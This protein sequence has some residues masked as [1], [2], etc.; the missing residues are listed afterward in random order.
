M[1][2]EGARTPYLGA[3]GPAG[4]VTVVRLYLV[5]AVVVVVVVVVLLADNHHNATTGRGAAMP[6]YDAQAVKEAVNL[7]DLAG[8]DTQLRRISG[9]EHA[10][11][12]PKCGGDDRFHVTPEWWFC[13]QCHERRGDAI[14]YVMWRD[15]LRFPDACEVLGG[16]RTALGGPRTG[17][18][19]RTAPPA[20]RIPTTAPPGDLWQG[21]ARSLVAYCE[22]LLW[23]T[24]A[25]LAHL[26]GRGLREDTIRAARLGWSEGYP[27]GRGRGED[28]ARW[29]VDPAKYPYGIRIPRG[30]VIPCEVGGQLRYIKVRRPPEDIAADTA[31]TGKD[32][33]KYLC[34]AGGPTAGVVYGLDDA[35]GATDVVLCEGEINA[36][37]L[38]QALE[39]VA[40]V[41]SV[42]SASSPPPG[43]DA[44]RV[45]AR[46]PRP[47][48][49]YDHDEQGERGAGNLQAL[50]ARVQPLSWPWGDRGD[51]YDI[52]DAGRDGEDLAAWCV[53]QLGPSEPDR[54]RDWL[55]YHLRR[56]DDAALEAGADDTDPA[57]RVWL[58]LWG[59]LE[60]LGRQNVAKR[61]V[62]AAQSATKRH[63]APGSSLVG[64]PTT[65]TTSQQVAPRA[66]KG[67][68][69][70]W[71]PP[72]PAGDPAWPSDPDWPGPGWEVCEAPSWAAL[73][74]PHHR[75]WATNGAGRWVSGP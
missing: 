6:S 47:W 21:R 20:V 14:G 12:C 62:A 44:L 42:G 52:A 48:A 31:R 13:R 19:R 68:P 7:V 73:E 66:T 39:G 57:L 9:D 72:R 54:R 15:D 3:G 51:K 71:N 67:Y 25:A 38:G 17:N 37:T 32:A 24:P 10:G 69:G 43:A 11:P 53:P 16:Q 8:A 56:L 46:V 70:G 2:L 59:E 45:L 60:A 29:G 49:A 18:T 1:A 40:G 35:Q 30:W 33:P 64:F 27:R 75:R 34:V 22:A 55:A 74:A 41:V 36:L 4:G 23:E 58:A 28:P 65:S 26:R 5:V 50:W 61:N 63:L